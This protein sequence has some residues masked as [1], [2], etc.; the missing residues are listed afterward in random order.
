MELVNLNHGQVTRKTLEL[1]PPSPN[2]HTIPTGGRLT[3]RQILCASLPYTAGL[4]W[5]WARTHVM[6][7]MIRYLDH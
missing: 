4:R 7:A 2:Y 5:Y 6:P 3:S 1:V